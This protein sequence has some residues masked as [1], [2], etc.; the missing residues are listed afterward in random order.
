MTKFNPEAVQRLKAAAAHDITVD[1]PGLAAQA[2]RASLVDEIQLIVCPV[3]VGGFQIV[4][5][6]PSR[7]TASAAQRSARQGR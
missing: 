5:S 7:R 3:L 4:A 1:G 6:E 2:M